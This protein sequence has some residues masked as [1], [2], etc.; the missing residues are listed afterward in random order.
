MQWVVKELSTLRFEIKNLKR[1]VQN[2][3]APHRTSGL[4]TL[5]HHLVDQLVEGLERFKSMSFTDAASFEHFN[6]QIKQL[7]GTMSQRLSTRM[8]ETTQNMVNAVCRV[9]GAEGGVEIC[10]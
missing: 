1:F 9:R 3:F 7:S 6:V 4:C 8:Q 10:R 5:K 2:S